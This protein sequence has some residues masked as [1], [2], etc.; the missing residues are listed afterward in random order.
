MLIVLYST[1]IYNLFFV[2]THFTLWNVLCQSLLLLL[3]D[4]PITKASYFNGPLFGVFNCVFT[5]SFCRYLRFSNS[6]LFIFLIY[7][8]PGKY[9]KNLTYFGLV[10]IIWQ[11]R[12]LHFWDIFCATFKHFWIDLESN[13]P[14]LTSL[15]I[16]RGIHKN[17]TFLQLYSFLDSSIYTFW[18][19]SRA[20]FR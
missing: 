16:V 15:M 4:C 7:P 20:F 14:I 3:F 13:R 5:F 12:K 18:D 6:N 8:F 11:N 17:I 9:F 2:W 19:I 1:N 10:K